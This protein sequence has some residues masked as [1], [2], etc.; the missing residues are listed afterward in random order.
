MWASLFRFGFRSL[1]K[2][3]LRDT[4]VGN[5]EVPCFGQLPKLTHLF[6]GHTRTRHCSAFQV[7]VRFQLGKNESIERE[8][9]K[10]SVI[11]AILA[12]DFFDVPMFQ[13]KD[14]WPKISLTQH[15]LTARKLKK[16]YS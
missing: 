9:V 13:D 3:D 14:T 1:E 8:N 7:I 2:L 15:L 4:S 10:K 11:L 16:E 12:S 5:S 6:F